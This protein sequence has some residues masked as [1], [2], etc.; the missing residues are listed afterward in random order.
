MKLVKKVIEK[1]TEGPATSAWEELPFLEMRF[2]AE[3]GNRTA[4]A[5]CRSPMRVSQEPVFKRFQQPSSFLLAL[6]FGANRALIL[7]LYN[8]GTPKLQQ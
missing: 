1:Q 5:R 6:I 8:L 4:L 2:V 3:E 7:K